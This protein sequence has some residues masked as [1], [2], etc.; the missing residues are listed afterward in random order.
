MRG[1]VLVVLLAIIAA[2]VADDRVKSIPGYPAMRSANY[3]GYIPIDTDGRKAFYWFIES[4]N[5]PGKDPLVLWLNG[6]PGCS[7]LA[8]CL[9]EIGPFVQ[10]RGNTFQ[11]NDFTWAAFT[12]VLFLESPSG[13]G[14]SIDTEPTT[15]WNDTA[16]AQLN[17]NF[18][19]SWIKQYSQFQ[20]HSFYIA[21]ESYAGHYIPQLVQMILHGPDATL[22]RMMKGFMAGNPCT[23]DIG[24]RNNDPTLTPWLTYN[25]LYPIN[26]SLPSGGG[27][28][29]HY[30]VL[31]RTC[32]T[33]LVSDMV[34]FDHPV[35]DA[36][37][38]RLRSDP[39]PFGECGQQIIAKWLNQPEV[40]AA[41]HAEPE[42]RWSL[43]GGCSYKFNYSGVVDVY[44]E[45]MDKTSWSI[46]IYSGLEDAVVNFAQ[47]ETVVNGM[48]RPLKN[49]NRGFIPWN[50]PDNYVPNATQF[51]G[52][53]IEY[54]RLS[55][56][57]VRDAGHMVP[58]TNPVAALELFRSFITLG[59]PGRL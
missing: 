48:K 42:K 25:G 57:G 50:Y 53:Y 40:K 11:R 46:L 6:G 35:L 23:G 18:L 31:V 38:R 45:L 13:V 19:S 21:G 2:A 14:F 7:S 1:V 43:C 59:R 33:S 36:Y 8:G 22:R 12:N 56:A 44:Q 15:Y 32:H 26:Q 9:L 37:R 27:D 16:T 54:D 39:V 34:Q 29:D 30:D 41:L 3:A 55:W 28:Y 20:S 10:G 4:E 51:G 24:C 52:Y 58:E 5:D 49:K 47:T 17:Y